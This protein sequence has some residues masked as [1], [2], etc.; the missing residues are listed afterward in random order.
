MDSCPDGVGAMEVI[1]RAEA[2]RPGETLFDADGRVKLNWPAV[3][4]APGWCLL[5]QLQGTAQAAQ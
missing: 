1:P 3:P 4:L 5:S 2:I